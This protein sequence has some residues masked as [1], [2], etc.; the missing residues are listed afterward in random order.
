[1]APEG[2][3]A[4]SQ[5][6]C[7]W[8]YRQGRTKDLAAPQGAWPPAPKV[9]RVHSP[10]GKYRNGRKH[11]TRLTRSHALPRMK[12]TWHLSCFLPLSFSSPKQTPSPV[13]SPQ[14]NVPV[15]TALASGVRSLVP[16][17]P[18][19]FVSSSLHFLSGHVG[20]F[21]LQ[22][23]GRAAE[24]HPGPKP[25]GSHFLSPSAAPQMRC[26]I[27]RPV[28]SSTGSRSCQAGNLECSVLLGASCWG[29]M[30]KP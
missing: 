30:R 2:P 5:S 26:F 20:I 3:K 15:A 19:V 17:C 6:R 28:A 16:W 10:C 8:S 7:L 24:G 4:G 23:L 27:Q 11:K 22:A 21:P 25:P 1:M 12:S 9:G 18:A 14:R 13:S 29:S